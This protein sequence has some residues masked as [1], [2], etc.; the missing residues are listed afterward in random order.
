M[1]NLLIKLFKDEDFDA[2][3]NTIRWNG[4]SRHNDESVGH[5]TYLVTVFVRVIL[6][7]MFQ[8]LEPVDEGF[9]ISQMMKLRVMTKALFHDFDETITGDVI[10]TVKYNKFNGEDIRNALEAYVHGAMAQKLDLGVPSELM[11]YESITD[12]K[13]FEKYLVKLGDWL[14][15]L[16]YISKEISLGNSRF[17]KNWG[18]AVEGTRGIANMLIAGQAHA[19]KMYGIKMNLDVIRLLSDYDYQEILK[20]WE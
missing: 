14:S 2:L 9:D 1:E 16:F 10:H 11:I 3:N 12:Q 15:V 20:N 17:K 4:K 8:H 18:Y 13:G 6:E 5:H 7:D 19:E